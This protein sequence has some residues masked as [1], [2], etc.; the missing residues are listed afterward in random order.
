M[1]DPVNNKPVAWRTHVAGSRKSLVSIEHP[2]VPLLVVREFQLLHPAQVC[3]LQQVGHSFRDVN[4]VDV[5]R[6]HV[7]FDWLG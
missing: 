1:D 4:R 7:I 2:I 3:G 6:F 5:L